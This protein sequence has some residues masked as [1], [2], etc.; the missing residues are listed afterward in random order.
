MGLPETLE[1]LQVRRLSQRR[2][3]QRRAPGDE[4]QVKFAK[5][6]GIRQRSEQANA[7]R[8]APRF[9]G[10]VQTRQ[11]RSR[12]PHRS[13]VQAEVLDVEARFSGKAAVEPE[14]DRSQIARPR[15]A[16]RTRAC[17]HTLEQRG[18]QA[19]ALI[20]FEIANT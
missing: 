20:S 9:D 8:C 1:V 15:V 3:H 13:R 16:E 12:L 11:Q 10:H 18:I 19:D 2:C 5:A 7:L 17:S 14:R 4:G 6:G